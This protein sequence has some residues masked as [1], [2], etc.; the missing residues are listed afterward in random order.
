MNLLLTT[1]MLLL[2]QVGFAQQKQITGTVQEADGFPLP[3][4]SVVIKGTTEGTSTDMD[5]NF[6]LSAKA[7]DV[8]TIS[9]LGFETQSIT[10]GAASNYKVV[11]REAS[12]QMDE[13]IVTTYG[14]QKKET[15]LGSNSVIKAE[16]LEQRPI[17]NVEKAL[18]GASPGVLVSTGSG[19]PGSG[20]N[21]QIR[22][23]SSANLS[24]SPLYIVDGAIYTG[25]LSDINSDDVE[26]INILKDAASTSLYGSAAANG[27][28]LI[29]TKKGKAGQKGR[30]NF[31]TSTGIVSK[32]IPE[33]NRVGAQDYY[34]MNWNALK[35]YA[36]YYGG[37]TVADANAYATRNLY[38]EVANNIYNVPNNQIVIDGQL[39]PDAE[40]LYNDFN[41]EKYLQRK[42]ISRTY[43]LNYSGGTDKSNFYASFGYNNEQGYVIKSDFERYTGRVSADSQVT[44]WLKLGTN[45]S[46]SLTNSNQAEDGGG[47]SYVN[48]FYSARFMGP[49][50]SPFVYNA[51]GVL[52]YDALGNVMYENGSVRDRGTSAGRGRNVLQE[53]LLNNRKR[54]TNSVNTR[55]FVEVKLLEG[56][57]FTSNVSYDVQNY[58]FTS[59][60]NK[61][62]GDA[63]GTGALAVTN[64][65]TSANT[66]NQILDYTFAFDKNHF[67]V[68]AGHESFERN[69]DYAYTRKTN[70]V[71][72]DNYILSNFIVT[73]SNTGY[74]IGLRKESY[75]GR[76]NYDYDNKYLV[77]ASIR[78]DQSSR[79]ASDKNKGTFWSAAAGWNMHLE[80]FLADSNVINQLKL[81][82]SYGQVGNDGGITSAPGYFADL[83]T[84]NLGGFYNGAEA[85]IFLDYIGNPDLTWESN[86][87]FD[88]A[89]EFSLF[90]H[91]LTG[92]VEYF[93][94]KTVD[95][96][97]ASPLPGSS[98]FT[99]VYRNVGDMSNR[100]FE[101]GATVGIIRNDNFK[102][103]F[104]LNATTFKNEM[105]RM[106][107][108]QEEIINGTKKLSKGHSIYDYWLRRW[109][110]VDPS[111]GK[112]LYYQDPETAD[113]STTRYINGERVTTNQSLAEYGYEGTANPDVYGSFV[114]N[115]EYKGFYLNVLVTYQ[116]GGKTYD[117]NYA[118]L[119]S[120]RPQG[121]ALHSDMKNAWK[122]PGDI[123]DVPLMTLD[124]TAAITAASSRWL[125]SSDYISLRN[126]TFGYNFSKEFVSKFKANGLRVYASAENIYSWT[127]RAG[128]E[129]AQ[130]FNGTTSYRYTPSRIVSF[131]LNVSF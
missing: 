123:T 72:A 15:S 126:A 39:N 73:T 103:D 36:Q 4:A 17:I 65:K 97:F 41:W 58:G 51:Q 37:Y 86:N 95:M 80:D 106:P 9:F 78:R 112:P 81:R 1:F 24:N 64:Q 68:I 5:G 110:G 120:P 66:F 49:I 128:L 47:S 127:K 83:T 56:L 25:S 61:I 11:M 122:Q 28:V 30:F 19:Q 45:M 116:L 21:V 71:V 18:D 16:A 55:Y 104:T 121:N 14:T 32:G 94:R 52:Q 102:W 34:E 108:G 87:Q 79:F 96:I 26:T 113:A 46:A 85:G 74:K 60:G 100:G 70:E 29:T 115:F 89:A 119:M 84:Y 91:R 118:G 7:G 63:Q 107:E 40:M 53:T 50:Y 98:G 82:A 31:S 57:K 101:L 54:E 59:Y 27:V 22:G 38:G 35:N 13:I 43:N 111:D 92:S 20:L 6:H 48:P 90:N 105:V 44:D 75:F 62:I 117:S 67:N 124:N 88:V 131:G 2:V 93:N 109:Y 12:N 76:V 8:L 114:N 10:V 77:S 42:G 129:P 23:A 3:G 33:Y 130:S 69:I 125:V 99:S